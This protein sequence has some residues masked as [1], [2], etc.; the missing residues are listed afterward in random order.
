MLYGVFAE[1]LAL[2]ENVG[3]LLAALF[4]IDYRK[5]QLLAEQGDLSLRRGVDHEPA[6]RPDDE[7]LAPHDHRNHLARVLLGDFDQHR[8]PLA[9]VEQILRIQG[10]ALDRDWVRE[11]L[12]EMYGSLDPRLSEWDSLVQETTQ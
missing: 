4:G 2:N 8:R 3:V 11:R 5:A 6:G 1:G 12:V 7:H 10:A 9:D